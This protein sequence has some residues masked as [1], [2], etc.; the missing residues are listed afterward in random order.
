MRQSHSQANT[1]LA[2]VAIL[3]VVGG[4]AIVAATSPQSFQLDSLAGLFG[5]ASATPAATVTVAPTA[6]ATVAEPTATMAVS[7]TRRPTLVPAL[8]T[9]TAGPATETA[10]P[11]APP[12]ATPITLPADAIALAQVEVQEAVNGRVRNRPDGDEVIAIVPNG[13]QLYI[14]QGQQ[15]IGDVIWVEVRLMD[16]V[17]GWMADFLLQILYRQP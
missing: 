17:T 6:T 13:T 12:S 16:G 9:S 7:P 8:V 15:Q 2:L 1:L 4:L 3:A 5:R 11:A 10:T 14:L